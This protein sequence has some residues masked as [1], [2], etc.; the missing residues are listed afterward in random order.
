MV[1]MVTS[2]CKFGEPLSK[3][4]T[5]ILKKRFNKFLTFFFITNKKE[6]YLILLNIITAT[7]IILSKNNKPR[8]LWF[9]RS[10]DLLK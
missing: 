6:N 5:P 7:V 10:P 4:W 9:F 1:I 8:M 2:E 3:A